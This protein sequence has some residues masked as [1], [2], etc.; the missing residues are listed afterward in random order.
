M[1]VV[2]DGSAALTEDDVKDHVRANLAR[3]KSPREVVFL[4]AI[5]Y[6]AAGKVA[7][8]ELAAI[9]VRAAGR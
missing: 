8:R 6:T 5:P 7:R 2:P 9:D 3:F 1:F 4:D